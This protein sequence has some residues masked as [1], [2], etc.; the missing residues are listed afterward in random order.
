M[1]IA[2]VAPLHESVHRITSIRIHSPG[3]LESLELKG[4]RV[5]DAVVDPSTGIA[6]MPASTC[7]AARDS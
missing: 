3:L 7:F 6:P 5:G 2:Q 1:R 4:R